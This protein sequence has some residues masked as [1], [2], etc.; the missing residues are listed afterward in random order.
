MNHTKSY[1]ALSQCFVASR[2]FSAHVSESHARN[3]WNY[4]EERE[5]FKLECP[6]YY[7]FFKDQV[8]GISVFEA[9]VSTMKS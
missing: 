1:C 5:L 2:A 7:N 3:E 8:C 4:E 9:D 6:K